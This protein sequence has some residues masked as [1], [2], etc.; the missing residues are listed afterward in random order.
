MGLGKGKKDPIAEGWGYIRTL[1]PFSATL[2]LWLYGVTRFSKPRERTH[3]R[4]P[5]GMRSAHVQTITVTIGA[6]PGRHADCSR[7]PP[8]H[9]Y[10]K[11]VTHR[12]G[13][14]QGMAC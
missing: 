12:H 10:Y 4:V 3:E 13:R 2:Y 14:G 7:N 1:K 9:E 5:S 11:S 6:I 8:W